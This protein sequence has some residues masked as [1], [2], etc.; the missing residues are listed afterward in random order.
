MLDSNLMI[1]SLPREKLVRIRWAGLFQKTWSLLGM[2]NH[3]MRISPQCRSFCFS[4]L[5]A[6]LPL[7]QDSDSVV[8][9]QADAW[10]DLIMWDQ[11][12]CD[13]NGISMLIPQPTHTSPR[14]FTD[15]TASVSFAAIFDQEWLANY[16]PSEV[17]CMSKFAQTLALFD[18]YPIL[19]AAVT[20]GPIWLGTLSFSLI[21]WPQ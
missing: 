10:A 4:R 16:W 6:L 21:I 17:F 3:A 14:V 20:W 12:L 9:L 11:F 18:M 5:L 7:Y 1:A 15:A 13:W 2:L 8:G 19:V